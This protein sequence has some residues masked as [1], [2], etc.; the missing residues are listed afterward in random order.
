[1]GCPK[2]SVIIPVYNQERY[3]KRCLDSVL[4]QSLYEVEILV[5][6]DGSIDNTA[7]IL[8]SYSDKIRIFK[9]KNSGP[10]GARNIGLKNSKGEYIF[11]LDSDDWIIFPEALSTLYNYAKVNDLDVL[12]YDF[13]RVKESGEIIPVILN[14][15]EYNQVYD[16]IQ[17]LDYFLLGMISKFPWDKIYKRKL[18]VKIEFYFPEKVWFEDIYQIILLVSAKKIMKLDY[19]PHAYWV[20][21]ASITRSFTERIYDKEKVTLMT[22]SK[23]KER[24]LLEG[25]EQYLDV[26]YL[27]LIQDQVFD[28]IHKGS[29]RDLRMMLNH[30]NE[31]Y[32]LSKYKK[33]YIKNR[34][35][36]KRQKIYLF[37]I[38]NKAVSI[39][40]LKRIFSWL[41]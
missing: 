39:L 8:D 13:N 23:L 41:R 35:L 16:G 29:L 21:S 33:K 34:Y 15:I 19:R 37:L 22:V 36:T 28:A 14:K 40:Y 4:S 3:I 11:L 26:F 17:I 9:T 24:K 2:I 18:I 27:I 7:I 6:D 31:C 1:M 32:N 12:M 30:I 5:I 10:G 20:G 25:K 38:F